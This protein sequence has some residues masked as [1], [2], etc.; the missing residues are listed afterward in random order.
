MEI[1][2]KLGGIIIGDS[3][4]TR[5]MGVINLSSTS[6]YK[7][8]IM[9]TKKEIESKIQY[10]TDNKADFIDIGTISSAPAFLYEDYEESNEET[11]I[12]RLSKFFEIFN[13]MGSKI[14]I[15]VDTQSSKVAEYALSHGA[16]II[17]DITGFKADGN[18][19][20]VIADYNASTIVMSCKSNP[21]DVYLVKDII[22]E[23]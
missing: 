13:E 4:K 3:V 18:L 22:I 7:G 17:N 19:P 14:D 15:S 5:I 12:K 8:S 21:G 20:R 9:K 10:M 6:F 23:L 16:S 1:K 11:E 2:G